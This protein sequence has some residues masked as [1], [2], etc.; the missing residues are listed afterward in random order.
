MVK[1]LVPAEHPAL[2]TSLALGILV[3]CLVGRRQKKAGDGGPASYSCSD[4]GFV[5]SQHSVD[6]YDPAWAAGGGGLEYSVLPQF[7]DLINL[8]SRT[9]A[10]YR[11]VRSAHIPFPR[12]SGLWTASFECLA[13]PGCA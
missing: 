9:E 1:V 7:S 12:V 13:F 6:S 4:H 2:K 8:L 11:P 3:F 10:R 5:L